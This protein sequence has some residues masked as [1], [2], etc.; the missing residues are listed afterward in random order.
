MKYLKIFLLIFIITQFNSLM[1]TLD[2]IRIKDLAN[3]IVIVSIPKSGTNLISKC[4][5]LLTNK[6]SN[7]NSDLQLF[8]KKDLKAV[9]QIIISHSMFCKKNV[10]LFNINSQN[11]YFFLYRDPRDVVVSLS[12]WVQKWKYWKP[13]FRKLKQEELIYSAIFNYFNLL[14][15]FE[16]IEREYFDPNS[17]IFSDIQS[18]YKYCYLPWR[19][20]PNFCTIQFEKLIGA[21]SGGSDEDQFNE[22]KKIANHLDLNC[23]DQEIFKIARQLYGKTATFRKGEIGS[24][25]TE[26]NEGHKRAFKAIAGKLLIQLGYEKDFNW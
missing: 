19:D 23:S 5:T 1:P 11:K 13:K 22:I 15:N 25:K 26:F 21:K 3:N 9:N 4:L 17:I 2:D 7:L 12:Y 20:Q 14:E 24:W 6:N 16:T 18:V 8:C 10:E